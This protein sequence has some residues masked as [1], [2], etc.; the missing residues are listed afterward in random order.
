MALYL[1]CCFRSRTKK[2]PVCKKALMRQHQSLFLY[3][4]IETPFSQKEA[5][6][7][8]AERTRPLRI[9]QSVQ[10]GSVQQ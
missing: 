7:E 6:F 5:S 8:A 4:Y 3:S 9:V 10:K 1:V 2:L